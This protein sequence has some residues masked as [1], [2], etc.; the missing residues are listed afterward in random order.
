MPAEWAPHAGTWMAWPTRL[1]VWRAG[2]APARAAFTDVILAI[3][4]FEPVTV[5]ADP[6][7][8]AEARAALPDHVRVVEMRHDDSWL[9]DS[10]P[11]VVLGEISNCP[12]PTIR[13]PVGIDWAFNGWGDLYGSFEQDKLVARKLCGVERMPYV[14]VDMVLEGGSIHVDGEGTMLTT[15]ECLL[16][17]NRNPSMTKADIEAELKRYTGVTKVVWLPKGLAFDDDTNGHVDNFA[18]FA[19][20]GVVLLAWSDDENDP[21]YAISR[22]ALEVLSRERDTKGRPFR[23]VKLPCPPPLYRT[24]EEWETLDE[25]GRKNRHAGERLAASYANF[26]VCNGAVIMP[27]F[28]LPDH[29]AAAAAALKAAFPGRTVV[30]V[31]T[32]EIVLGGGNVHC[33]TQQQPA[34]P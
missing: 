33:I 7:A 4:R 21:Q 12:Q 28:G 3:A 29:D 9:R 18:C 27:A 5:I 26:Y 17:P 2:A 6:A 22:E 8:W 19:E 30:A 31:G 1:D 34:L 32:R 10:G 20:P 25:E 15:E 14:S 13:L 24:Q 16:H 23:V 11:T